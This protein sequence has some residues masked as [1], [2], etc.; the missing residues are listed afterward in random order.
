M[1]EK[2]CIAYNKNTEIEKT[3]VGV[4]NGMPI[5]K[6]TEIIL[7]EH[8]TVF[9]KSDDFDCES[10]PLRKELLRDENA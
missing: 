9:N 1:K 3:I 8:C 10:C 4:V 2:N 7:S 6:E 5:F